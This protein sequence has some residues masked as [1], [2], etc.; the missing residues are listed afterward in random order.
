MA[1]IAKKQTIPPVYA[2]A[3]IG[4]GYRVSL[5]STLNA[6][7]TPVGREHTLS[8][9]HLGNIQV[10]LGNFKGEVEV[11]EVISLA[12]KGNINDTKE[13]ERAK[14]IYISFGDILL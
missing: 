7:G 12:T 10:L 13:R 4:I 6:R 8:I 2:C 9:Q 5:H 1:Q 14:L 11:V 3:I